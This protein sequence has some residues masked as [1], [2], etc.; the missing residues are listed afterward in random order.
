MAL[1]RGPDPTSDEPATDVAPVQREIVVL[2]PASGTAL[3]DARLQGAISAHA[4]QVGVQLRLVRSVVPSVSTTMLSRGAHGVIR[5]DLAEGGVRMTYRR[6][7]DPE[8]FARTLLTDEAGSDVVFKEQ[9]ANVVA[10]IALA[11][12]DDAALPSA[13]AAGL[14]PPQEPLPGEEAFNNAPVPVELEP[15]PEPAEP[16][17]R[18][19]EALPPPR[20]FRLGLSAGYA[21]QSFGGGIAWQNGAAFSL[22]WR[23]SPRGV[24]ELGVDAL[25][26]AQ[27]SDGIVEAQLR[28]VPVWLR[29]LAHVPISMRWSFD[30]GL[31]ASVDV[32]QIRVRVTPP[33]EGVNAIVVDRPTLITGG[34]GPRLG[35]VFHLSPRVCLGLLLGIDAV[36]GQER[37]RASGR[38]NRDLVRARPVRATVGL[39]VDTGLLL[40]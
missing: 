4:E 22:G 15:E 2:L 9:L 40:R 19:L 35:P 23:P 1:A 29:G 34:L 26:P 24:L 20:W 3:L 11:L 33:V 31:R 28:R 16:A 17:P 5:L 18:I 25:A 14:S 27:R 10:S 21:G 6:T 8:L 32:T 37:L 36:L 39:R 38:T 30:V 12:V 7:Q 13:D